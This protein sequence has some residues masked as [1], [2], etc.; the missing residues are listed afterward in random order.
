MMNTD[1]ATLDLFTAHALQRLHQRHIPIEA[2][3]AALDWGVRRSRP[4]GACC[5]IFGRR[6]AEQAARHGE[7]LDRFEGLHVIVARGRILTAYWRRL[8]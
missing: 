4:G 7:A 8:H 1:E 2:V 6:Q 5:Y 3:L